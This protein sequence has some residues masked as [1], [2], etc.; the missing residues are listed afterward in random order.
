MQIVFGI[1][2]GTTNSALSVYREG[3]VEVV[4]I[5]EFGASGSLM[6]SVLYFNEESQVFAGGEAIK[7]YVDEGAAG[8]F[9][10]SVKTFLPNSSFE[11]TEVFGK[12]YGIEDFLVVK[13]LCVGGIK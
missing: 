13:Y 3:R 9:M 7:N 11:S 4:D 2:F 8:R 10:Q 1:D 6:R 5:D 12:K